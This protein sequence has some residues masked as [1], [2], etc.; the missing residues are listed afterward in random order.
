VTQ[1]AAAPWRELERTSC[2]SEAPGK[3]L[4][5]EIVT[6]LGSRAQRDRRRRRHKRDRN[7]R[8]STVKEGDKYR[9]MAQRLREQAALQADHAI[10]EQ[11]RKIADRYDE[12]AE[13]VEAVIRRSD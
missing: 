13:Q 5:R 12:L 1:P 7:S 8:V 2:A 9:S 10:S 11:Y 4:L 3:T 6:E